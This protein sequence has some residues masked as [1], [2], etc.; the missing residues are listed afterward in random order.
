MRIVL[1]L[2]LAACVALSGCTSDKTITV[3]TSKP[4]STPT[5]V[6][7]TN[8]PSLTSPRPI[9]PLTIEVRCHNKDYMALPYRVEFT[10]AKSSQGVSVVHEGN[11]A[12]VT[13]KR[14]SSGY[15]H[16]NHQLKVICGPD[17]FT[18]PDT[19]L[20]SYGTVCGTYYKGCVI[21]RR[22]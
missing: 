10:L 20:T 9:A 8:P 5:F 2:S 13:V 18:T 22:S 15:R 7:P 19:P 6:Q 4:P 1:A 14:T 21:N 12:H 17:E 3:A 11:V 16:D